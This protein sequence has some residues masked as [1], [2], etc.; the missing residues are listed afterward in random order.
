MASHN[1]IQSVQLILVNLFFISLTICINKR[2]VLL[3]Y[4]V[5]ENKNVA[6]FKIIIVL[7]YHLAVFD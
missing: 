5:I 1:I 7:I 3:E 2:N 6:A 4:N